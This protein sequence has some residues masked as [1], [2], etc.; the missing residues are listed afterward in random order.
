MIKQVLE[1]FKNI[2]T[3]N[4]KRLQLNTANEK[5]QK[6]FKPR[7]TSYLAIIYSNKGYKIHKFH[8]FEI[9]FCSS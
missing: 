3:K 5:E 2:K 8:T 1:W 9:P 7:F 4:I 6:H